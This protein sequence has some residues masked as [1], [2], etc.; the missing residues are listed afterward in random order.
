MS[1]IP[2]A[3]SKPKSSPASCMLPIP[4]KKASPSQRDK[5]LRI[6][7]HPRSD[8]FGYLILG[9]EYGWLDPFILFGLGIAESSPFRQ[10]KVDDLVA[11][12]GRGPDRCHHPKGHSRYS[13]FLA[14][15][16]SSRDQ[17]IFPFFDLSSRN[18]KDGTLHSRTI[19]TDENNPSVIKD[20]ENGNSLAKADDFEIPGGFF[21][22]NLHEVHTYSPSLPDDHPSPDRIL[23]VG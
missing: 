17:N 8:E 22:R 11:K 1:I 12:S 9:I 7:N 3:A 13:G 21:S 19:L 23:N 20:R 10:N 5:S 4:L 2:S 6:T 18:F 14:Q 16:S 15:F